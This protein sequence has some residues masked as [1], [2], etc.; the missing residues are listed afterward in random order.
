MRRHTKA[1]VAA[2]TLLGAGAAVATVAAGRWAF[3]ATLGPARP[4]RPAGFAEGRFAVHGTAA[5]QVTLTRSLETLRPGTYGL[6]AGPCHAVVGPVLDVPSGPDSVVRR[7]ERVDRGALVPGAPAALTPQLHVGTP[8]SA[9]GIPYSDVTVPGERGPLPTWFVPGARDTWV[10]ALHGLGATRE[11]PL[12]LLPFLHEQRFPVLVPGHRGDAGT[13]RPR[14]GVHRLGAAEW[15]DAD[16][17]LRFAAR[18]G[19]RRVVLYGWST[20]GAMALRTATRSA[21]RGLVVGLVLDSPVLDPAAT[22]HALAVRRGVPGRLVPLALGAARGGF[23]LDL[24]D[25]PPGQP[26]GAGG[27]PV[28]VLILHGPADT[29]APWRASR[30][31]AARHPESIVLHTVPDAEHAAMWNTAPEAY[32][33]RLRRFLTPLM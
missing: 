13:P 17:A 3:G 32:E 12:N 21:L 1:A 11:H 6:T 10:I 8:E 23:G 28:P 9:L 25:R 15:H 5:G 18:R 26:L 31:L 19:A 7:L 29:I 2:T 4:A 33:E 22:L 24:D 27:A 14:E 20:G 30:E 16:A